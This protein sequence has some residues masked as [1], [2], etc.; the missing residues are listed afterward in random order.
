MRIER[1]QRMRDGSPDAVIAMWRRP[2][3]EIAAAGWS[4]TAGASM[5][6]VL[7]ATAA[8]EL[9]QDERHVA[10]RDHVIVAA[11]ACCRFMWSTGPGRA[12]AAVLISHGWHRFRV[13]RCARRCRCWR[14]KLLRNAMG[15]LKEP[16]RVREGVPSGSLR[17]SRDSLVKSFLVRRD[18]ASSPTGRSP[19]CL[20]A[21]WVLEA[22]GCCSVG[23]RS[24]GSSRGRP[25]LRCA[26][27]GGWMARTSSSGCSSRRLRRAGARCQ[28]ALSGV[29]VIYGRRTRWFGSAFVTSSC[30]GV[31]GCAGRR[32]VRWHA[33]CLRTLLVGW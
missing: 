17:R 12:V 26:G 5:I 19:S 30:T 22:L 1:W 18:C 6:A 14:R 8:R 15:L 20:R 3:T 2:R 21:R 28:T 9:P 16:V 33:L 11:H 7:S 10:A 24:Q 29:A 4:Q 23:R 27:I 25:V 32:I 13:R 31:G